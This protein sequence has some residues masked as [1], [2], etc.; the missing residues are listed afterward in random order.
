[1]GEFGADILWLTYWG[2]LTGASWR[3]DHIYLHTGEKPVIWFTDVFVNIFLHY[4]TDMSSNKAILATII[5]PLLKIT[6][7]LAYSS[8]FI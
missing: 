5:S 8:L 1:M 6:I 7:N 2:K 4:F 3:T